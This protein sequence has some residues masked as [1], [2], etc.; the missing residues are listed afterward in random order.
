MLHE[1]SSHGCLQRAGGLGL[2]APLLL[3]LALPGCASKLAKKELQAHEQTAR[4]AE[5]YRQAQS[6]RI[7]SLEREIARLRKDLDE[8]EG[9]MVAIES[10]LRGPQTRADA[11]SALAEA[12][13][14]L[15]RARSTV[16]WRSDEIRE[17]IEKIEEAE[18][19]FQAGNVGSA[20]FFASRAQRIADM[21]RDE[22]RRASDAK[23]TR[24]VVAPRVNMRA[25]PS[26]DQPIV[27][28]LPEATPVLPQRSEGEWMLVRTLDGAAGWVHTSLLAKP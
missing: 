3:S 21:L 6:E 23:G 5:I 17:V 13:I 4:D 14:S 1:R 20:V 12:R 26:T 15:E 10:G 25:G 7:Q 11:V 8:A 9:A 16:R 27:L 28:V 19:Q 2:L 22:G 24:V 18:R